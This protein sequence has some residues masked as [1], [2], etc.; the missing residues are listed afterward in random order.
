LPC[1][2]SY[3]GSLAS[4]FICVWQNNIE[5]LDQELHR[6]IIAKHDSLPSTCKVHSKNQY[7]QQYRNTIYLYHQTH[8]SSPALA[9][10]QKL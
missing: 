1:C 10:R 9:K 4:A 3:F 5:S 8:H 6:I 2:H 7:D